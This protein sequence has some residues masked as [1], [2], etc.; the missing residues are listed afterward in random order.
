MWKI[1]SRMLGGIILASVLSFGVAAQQAEIEGAISAQIEAFKAD[2]FEQAFTYATPTLQRL[3][4]SPQNFQRMVT[5]QYP[6][7]WRPAEVRY[8]ERKAYEGSVFQ[9]VQ[10]VD[11]KGVMFLLLYQ[12]QE[13]DA[14]WRIAGV[15]FLEAP[16]ASV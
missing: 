5:T 4:Q 16:G 1:V 9:K 3:F 14:G 2:D 12:M 6:M 7:V 11:A 10:I 8:L 15:Q 13:T